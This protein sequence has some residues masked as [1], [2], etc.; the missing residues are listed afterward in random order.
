MEYIKIGYI[1]NTLGINGELKVEP[2]TSDVGRFGVLESCYINMGKHRKKVRLERYRRYKKK[3]VIVKFEG[4]DDIASVERFKGRYMEIDMENAVRLPEGHYFIFQLLG[5][6]VYTSQ[7]DDLGQVVEVLQPGGNDVYVVKSP[8]GEVLIPA[9][10]D[11]VR[12]I[13]IEN[14]TIRVDLP[15]GLLE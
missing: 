2:L 10:K 9:L 15:E 8:A 6:R 11:V 12:E 5:C 1:T 3:H 4:L 13:D 7:G 14:K